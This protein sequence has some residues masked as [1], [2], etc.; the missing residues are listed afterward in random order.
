MS[1]RLCRK[2][3]PLWRFACNCDECSRQAATIWRDIMGDVVEGK[4]TL[5]QAHTEAEASGI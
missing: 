1:N 3:D 4:I 5:D 2:D